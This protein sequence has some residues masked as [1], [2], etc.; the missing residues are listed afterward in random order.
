[1]MSDLR[2]NYVE[3]ASPDIAASKQFFANA[4]GWGFD[5]YGPEYQAF[6]DAGIDGGIDGTS[7]GP[8]RAP[9]VI[10][11]ADDLEA[12]LKRVED[13]GGVVTKP[14]FNFP[15]GR[16]FEFREPGGNELAVWSE[17]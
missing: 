2:I 17:A 13:A 5:D 7:N 3:F 1:M 15:G 6:A 4:F 11:K 14:I 16:R 10:L 8:A 12:A 9:L